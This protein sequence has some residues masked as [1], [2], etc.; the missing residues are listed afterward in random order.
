MGHLVRITRMSAKIKRHRRRRAPPAKL[1]APGNS[2]AGAVVDCRIDAAWR[3]GIG[4]QSGVATRD[5]RPAVGLPDRRALVTAVCT[6]GPPVAANPRSTRD[7]VS[8]ASN[9]RAGCRSASARRS[10]VPAPARIAESSGHQT[11][12]TS[13]WVR[14][15][16]IP[17]LGPNAGATVTFGCPLLPAFLSRGYRLRTSTGAAT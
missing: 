3:C 16:A 14:I 17:R 10:D 12:S 13:C 9:A 6:S 4:S 1:C 5:G 15:F 2:A 7:P 8:V 11:D